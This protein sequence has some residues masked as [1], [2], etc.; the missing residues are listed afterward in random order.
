MSRF[1]IVSALIGISSALACEGEGEH[2]EAK[3]GSHCNMPAAESTTAALPSDVPHAKLAVTGMSCGSCADAVH[4]AL[5]G[6]DGVTGAQVDLATAQV[7]VAY[8]PKKVTMDKMIAAV[9]SNGHFKA[10]AI[11]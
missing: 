4:A 5:M 2:A 3:S 7:E 11:N 9:G 6:L 10:S 8:D 1:L